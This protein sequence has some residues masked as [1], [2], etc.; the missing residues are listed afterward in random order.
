MIHFCLWTLMIVTREVNSGFSRTCS[1]RSNWW[2]EMVKLK[3]WSQHNMVQ[4][5]L[6]DCLITLKIYNILY[7]WF[8]TNSEIP[9][10]F[11]KKLSCD[12]QFCLIMYN[13]FFNFTDLCKLYS[14]RF[15]LFDI[16]TKPAFQQRKSQNYCSVYFLPEINLKWWNLASHF[17]G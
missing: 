4:I 16:Q 11:K 5:K 15:Y 14:C 10:L 8:S 1:L 9:Y 13:H 3:L 2:Y 12:G 7:M 6:T 17:V